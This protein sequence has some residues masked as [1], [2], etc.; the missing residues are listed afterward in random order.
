[1][2]DVLP[3][4][5]RIPAGPFLMGADDGDP[6]QRPVHVVN[7]DEFE[8]GASAVTQAEYARFVHAT[9]RRAPGVWELPAVAQFAAGD[10]FRGMAAPYQWYE[11]TPPDE[12]Q[13]HPV[14]LVTYEDASEYC[15][16]L[17]H[18]TGR[19]FRLPT[20]AESEKA[21]RGGLEGQRYPWGHTLTHEQAAWRV[22]ATEADA[23]APT[24]SSETLETPDAVEPGTRRVKSFAPN[25]YGMFDP[26][27]NVWTW[28][29]DW[30]R[31]DYYGVCDALNPRGPASGSLRVLRG[32]AWTNSD[33]R[34]LRCAWRHPVPPDT[35]GYS[36]GFRVVCSTR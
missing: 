26:A 23:S 3:E 16:W 5:V 32:G 36:I 11:S 13:D 7:L 22:A 29:A 21:A 33:E 17:K 18:A 31:A 1:M 28:V 12:R 30:Y 6:S 19:P 4:L 8:I 9:A 27:G 20:E 14:V 35:Y 10:R 34:Y 15:R 24:V 25:R 2:T